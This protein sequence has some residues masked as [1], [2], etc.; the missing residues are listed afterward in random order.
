MWTGAAAGVLGRDRGAAAVL[1]ME[2]LRATLSFS[3]RDPELRRE[4][5]KDHLPGIVTA[6]LALAVADGEKA[7]AT[8]AARCAAF[9]TLAACACDY[10]GPTRPFAGKLRKATLAAI[11]S[12]AS[13]VARAAAACFA[14]IPASASAKSQGEAWQTVCL[15]L[16]GTAHQLVAWMYK[17]AEE[18]EIWLSAAY[19]P[20][21]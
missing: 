6:L 3:C 4:H 1:A 5:A 11:D 21:M 20:L 9:E 17:G 8:D 2:C 12:P 10:P 13:V 14:R 16:L 18:E 19:A 7:A 15:S